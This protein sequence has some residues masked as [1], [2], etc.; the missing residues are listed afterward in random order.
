MV[1]QK[2]IRNKLKALIF[3]G[4]SFIGL[5]IN[6]ILEGQFVLIRLK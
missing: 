3:E 5:G 4:I 1:E 2:S 6:G